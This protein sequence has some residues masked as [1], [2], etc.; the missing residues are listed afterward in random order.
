MKAGRLKPQPVY[1]GG[2]GRVFTEIYDLESHRVNRNH[3]NL[4]LTHALNLQVLSGND[5]QGVRLSPG[6]IF[7]LTSGMMVEKTAAHDLALRLFADEKHA[8]FFVGYTDPSTP[9][10][11]LR[12]SQRGEKFHF[13]GASGEVVRNCAIHEFDLTAHAFREDLL[14]F[15]GQ[16]R[17]RTVVL[18]HGDAPARAW[19]ALAIQQKFPRIKVFQPGPGEKVVAD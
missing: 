7:V 8:I 4:K 3:T 6:R 14:E 15:V 19:F 12:A 9:G 18:G 13:S 1:I 10:G 16:V 5:S 11:R 2:L 17:P